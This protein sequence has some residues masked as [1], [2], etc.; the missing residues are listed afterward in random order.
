MGAVQRLWPCP[1]GQEVKLHPTPGHEVQSRP[2]WPVTSTIS[3]L[4]LKPAGEAC[5]IDSPNRRDPSS[6]SLDN[7]AISCMLGDVTCGG[8]RV[9]FWEKLEGLPTN[10]SLRALAID[11]ERVERLLQTPKEKQQ[12]AKYFPLVKNLVMLKRIE[13]SKI[14]QNEA[15]NI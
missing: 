5:Q 1:P 8:D 11:P 9:S 14:P 2:C 13:G 15:V 12:T 6:C 7:V 3:L 4:I 10:S